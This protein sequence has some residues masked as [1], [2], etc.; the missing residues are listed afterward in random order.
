MTDGQTPMKMEKARNGLYFVAAVDADGRL[1]F[2]PIVSA[3]S[4]FTSLIFR[5]PPLRLRAMHSARHTAQTAVQHAA[6]LRSDWTLEL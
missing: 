1:A 2:N 3:Y 5:N 4:T 6:R